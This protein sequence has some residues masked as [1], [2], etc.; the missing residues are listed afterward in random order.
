[1]EERIFALVGRLEADGQQVH[2]RYHAEKGFTVVSR[3][4]SCLGRLGALCGLRGITARHRAWLLQEA[5]MHAP[6]CDFLEG[7]GTH[8]H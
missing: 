7:T 1:M 5:R 2:L 4:P 3:K 8:E 6:S